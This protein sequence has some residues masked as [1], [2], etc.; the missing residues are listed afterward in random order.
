MDLFK[1][2]LG[3]GRVYPINESAYTRAT[4]MKFP[5]CL[6]NAKGGQSYFAICPQCENPIQIIGL[7]K[8]T[9]EGG[10]KPY[11]K[12]YNKSIPKLAAYHKE[13]YLNCPYSSPN[14]KKPTAKRPV[15][16][17]V[18][19]EILCLLR[20]QFDR[21]VYILSHDTEIQIGYNLARS[22][23]Q[24]Y[25]G[26][27]G[28]RYR[29]ATLNNLPWIF[30]LSQKATPL[31]GRSILKNG[32]LHKALN[33]QCPDVLFKESS[34]YSTSSDQSKGAKY[35][36]I[37]NQPN[38]Y[39]NIHYLFYDYSAR[40]VGSTPADESLHETIKFWVY[41]GSAPNLKTL[42][43]KELE[44]RTEYFLNLINLPATKAKRNENYL[45]IANE[46]I[47]VI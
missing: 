15:E 10:Q 18:A 37:S 45:R 33:D 46:L 7:Y 34:L 9:I 22:M 13:D 1:T 16:S 24:T 8:N 26:Q 19:K 2:R 32:E 23:L 44:I 35:V 29:A 36:Q 43:I 41:E 28:W 11:G 38:K 21:V 4:G 27:E 3:A 5:Y 40:I 31:F 14:W 20:D 30:G 39:L 42:Y 25:L 6:P 17:I 47:P 12:H